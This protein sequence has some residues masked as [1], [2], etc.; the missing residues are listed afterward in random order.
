M[1]RRIALAFAVLVAV[2]LVAAVLP[3]GAAMQSREEQSFRFATISDARQL[4]AAAEETLDDHHA[5]G[6]MDQAVADAQRHGDCAAVYTAAAT[7]IASTACGTAKDASAV[8]LA[9]RALSA[10]TQ[11]VA[12]DGDWLRAAIPVG[13]DDDAGAVVFARSAES[14]DHRVDVMWGWLALTAAA[15]LGLGVALAYALAR[16]VARPLL[17]LDTAA[18]R[19]GEGALDVRAP[20][21][22]GP[23]EV[24]RLAETFNRMAERTETLVHGHRGWV[25]DVSHQ[26]RTPLTA[27]RLRLD[28]LVG[29]V[30]EAAEQAGRPADLAA[31]LISVQEEIERLSRLVDGLLAVARAESVVAR[32]EAV[33][34]ADI[35]AE[36]VVAWEPL[37]HEHG[38]HLTAVAPPD[39]GPLPAV[40]APGDLEQI[41]DNL[42]ANALAAVPPG[43]HV[44]VEAHA[45][46]ERDRVV[47]R[48]IDDGPGMSPAAKQA[49]FRRFGTSSGT[50]SGLG[51]AIVDRL[52][53][54]NGGEVRLADTDTDTGTNSGTGTGADTDPDA[55]TATD[56]GGLTVVVELP[57]A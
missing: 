21:E 39:G 47:V 18:S 32:R 16:W 36:R 31:E 38:Q 44:R 51:L 8:A 49:A 6:P 24:R 42:I 35:A 20:A 30:G 54:A 9:R 19:L 48:V 45:D 34:V 25:A 52:V 41:L 10:R 23:P 12:R 33:P 50:G 7:V 1:T 22:S 28:V 43:G 4:T 15:C 29:E 17:A 40:L 2:L 3:L 57:A 26:L 13:D 5:P 11:I 37:A 14:L 27:L 55:R 53:S 56:T 46:R